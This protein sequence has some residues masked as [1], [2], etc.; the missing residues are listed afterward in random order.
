[1]LD[2]DRWVAN[3]APQ[4][5]NAT[6]EGLEHFDFPLRVLPKCSHEHL[7]HLVEHLVGYAEVFVDICHGSTDVEA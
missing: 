1:M 5:Y 3:L 4:C 7:A 6:I 2:H